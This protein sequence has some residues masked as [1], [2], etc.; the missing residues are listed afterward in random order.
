[1]IYNHCYN[2]C[3]DNMATGGKNETSSNLRK[4][5]TLTL[6]PDDLHPNGIV[7]VGDKLV[8]ADI[9]SNKVRVY[10]C[11]NGMLLSSTDELE[12]GPIGVCR[13]SD[14]E[15]C[16]AIT[17]GIIEIMSVQ[18][19][20]LISRG[21]TFHLRPSFKYCHDVASWND[22]IVVSGEKDDTIYWCVVSLKHG[23]PDKLHKVCD[24]WLSSLTVNQDM[25]Y[26]ACNS[27]SDDK[28]G[29]YAFNLLNPSQ[30]TY[31]YKHKELSLTQCIT[32]ND[33][34]HLFVCDWSSSIYHLTGKCQYVAIYKDDVPREPL[35]ISW[36]RGVLYLI[37]FE[38]NV[39][40]MYKTPQQGVYLDVEESR[41][42]SAPSSCEI[43]IKK[44]QTCFCSLL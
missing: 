41:R 29:V 1:L 4:V 25:V 39:I 27:K 36:D 30:P 23:R 34:G 14:T 6:E 22:N 19:S 18:D 8:I 43:H 32:V 5:G 2:S 21:P 33:M 17:N 7:G 42:V 40:T 12:S 26:I 16:V 11:H 20:G 15:L 10:R 44:E 3:S 28:S 37:S 9:K 31:T 24:G 13:V 38:S 35:A